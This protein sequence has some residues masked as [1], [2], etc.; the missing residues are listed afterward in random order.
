MTN[1]NYSKVLMITATSAFLLACSDTSTETE[2]SDVNPV[3]SVD[4]SY[5]SVNDNRIQTLHDI[6]I[7]ISAGDGFSATEAKNREDVFHGAPYKISLAAL[8]D[9]DSALM[10]H[11]ETVADLS[12]ASDYSNLP[13]ADWPN[14][15]FRSGDPVCMDIPLE[16]TEGEHDLEWL[17][18]NGFE[19][20]GAIVFAQ[21]F[22]TTA[23]N[24]SEIVLSILVRV[25][26]CD[27]ET[28]SAAIVE[29]FQAG[30]TVQP[31]TH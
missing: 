30:I 12:G 11:A 5:I 7:E 21:Y 2:S 25:A 31:I 1:T 8:I 14:E 9:D 22:A 15:A 27:D 29:Q 28:D 17:R 3:S 24:N 26:S 18:D 23:D 10:L 13:Q 6:P 16:A 4:F 20:T 19:P